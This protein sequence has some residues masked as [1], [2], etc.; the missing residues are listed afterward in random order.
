MHTTPLGLSVWKEEI[1]VQKSHLAARSAAQ[2]AAGHGQPFAQ[3]ETMDA[4]EKVRDGRQEDVQ[5]R[6]HLAPAAG[7]GPWRN[8]EIQATRAHSRLNHGGND[9]DND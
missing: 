6:A 8:G 9:G 5:T 2:Q 1:P 4:V 7:Y 3:E